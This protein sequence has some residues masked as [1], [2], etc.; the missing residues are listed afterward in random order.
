MLFKH[1]FFLTTFGLEVSY[2]TEFIYNE[3]VT[4]LN[5]FL[6]LGFLSLEESDLFL[7]LGFLILEESDFSYSIINN[8]IVS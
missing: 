1:F 2:F 8:L 4:A 3:Y 5:L 7:Y 6:Y